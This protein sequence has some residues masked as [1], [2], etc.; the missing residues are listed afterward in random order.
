MLSVARHASAVFSPQS[1]LTGWLRKATWTASAGSAGCDPTA[2][3]LWL[4]CRGRTH[5]EPPPSWRDDGRPAAGHRTWWSLCQASSH[6][7][8]FRRAAVQ[9]VR[10]YPEGQRLVAGVAVAAF[11]PAELCPDHFVAAGRLTQAEPLARDRGHGRLLS[12]LPLSTVSHTGVVSRS[13]AELLARSAGLGWWSGRSGM[14]PRG[15][16]RRR[17]TG[18][19]GRRVIPS[20]R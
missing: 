2:R 12:C 1:P 15:G 18:D 9:R 17:R 6:T 7:R 8:R 11:V 3:W 4:C 13:L 20:C 10:A 16:R 5:P 14:G 19:M